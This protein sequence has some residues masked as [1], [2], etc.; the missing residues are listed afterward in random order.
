M[1]TLRFGV[2]VDLSADDGFDFDGI[3]GRPLGL[4]SASAT[5][6]VAD[7]STGALFTILGAF[8]LSSETAFRNSRVGGF[9]VL[10]ADGHL[11]LSMGGLSGLT[12]A[13][14]DDRVDSGSILDAVLAQAAAGMLVSGSRYDDVLL[15]Y[16][17]SDSLRGNGGHDQLRAAAGADVLTG[18]AGDD[19]LNGGPGSDR[20]LGGAGND[21]YWVDGAGD[22]LTEGANGGDD[23]VRALATFRLPAHVEH[24]LLL[25]SG[26]FAAT[27]N[28][29]GN[30]L[31]G[32]AGANVLT[33]LNGDDLLDG[34]RGADRME[35]GR[36]DDVY[37]VG[38]AAD[39]VVERAG[40]GIDTVRSTVTY[41][42]PAQVEHLVLTGEAHRDGTGNGLA[43]VLV[44][45]DGDNVLDGRGGDDVMVGGVGLDTL[46][47]GAGSDDFLLDALT[48]G[49]PGDVITDFETGVDRL[50]LDSGL[51]LFDPLPAGTQTAANFILAGVAADADDH[52]VYD[53]ADGV[54]Y[55]DPDPVGAALPLQALFDLGDGTPL[56]AA[57][58][59]VGA[60]LRV[61]LLPNG[62]LLPALP[63]P[64]WAGDGG[65]AGAGGG[66]GVVSNLLLLPDPA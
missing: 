55:F 65:G 12:V 41:R 1:L 3:V 2:R 30:I 23:V 11:L 17:G 21:T 25:G 62:G 50:L 64:A 27:G 44:G 20:M 63:T 48:Y 61:D 52:L 42:L 56:A 9:Q 49:A 16:S 10:D 31:Q 4:V 22:R 6:L 18:G 58:L 53:L 28:G 32:N 40:E 7:T 51:S 46:T 35:G 26:R 5:R 38:T 14:F 8:D 57:D 47:G 43:N 54:L 29:A 19:R 33:G 60:W 66:A 37:V 36:G 34:G 45:N 15:G 39:R 24:L 13:M 59:F